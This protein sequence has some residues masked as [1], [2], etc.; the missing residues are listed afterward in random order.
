V[1]DFVYFHIDSI[2]VECAI[3]NFADN[4]LVAGAIALMLLALRPEANPPGEPNSP[5]TA[6]TTFSNTAASEEDRSTLLRSS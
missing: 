4:M 3:F 6:E 2:R 1:R 5:G